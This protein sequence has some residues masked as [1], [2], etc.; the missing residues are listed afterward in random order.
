LNE[1]KRMT[2]AVE[3]YDLLIVGS[4]QAGNPL[5]GAF[6][7]AGRRVALVERA[8][9][10]GTCINYGCTP[11]KTM[12]ASAQRAHLART[13]PPL[14]VDVSS[15]RVNMERVRQRKRE[16]VAQFREGNEKRFAKGNPELVR[17]V[18]SFR[19][20]DF[21]RSRQV[22][23]R[24]NE[25]GERVLAAD[26]IVIDTGTSPRA[27]Q[28]EG[29][30]GVPFLDNVSVM[31]LGEVPRHLLVL[32]GG[33]IGVEFGQMFRRFGSEV[34]LLQAG[35]QILEREDEDI[36][37]EAEKILREDGVAIRTQVRVRAVSGT[38]G[39][40]QV[41]LEGGE[42]VEG[43]HLLVATGRAPNTADLNLRA[44][45][46]DCD[47][48]GY[49]RVNERLETTAAGVYAVGD[50]KG[51]P[52]FTHIAYDDFR[53][54]RENLLRGGSRTTKDRPVP[55]VVYM[56]PQLGRVGMTEREA[57]AAGRAIR[58]AKMPYS[59]VARAVETGETRGVM[60]VLV[61]SENGQIL[62]AAMLGAEGGEMM[63]M[64]E[65]AMMGRLPYTALADAVLAHPALAEAL[66]NVFL[67]WMDQS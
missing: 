38:E 5:A 55:Y 56:D 60:K 43:S 37:A 42:T 17:G 41:G 13:A 59:S 49:I 15:V 62:G 23:V 47:E 36:A 16:I 6:A 12:A 30:G 63:S 65:I 27:P 32:G 4:G 11:T 58:V 66:N 22:E 40:I 29:L 34:T 67:H 19:D 26:L 46:V 24:L 14:G 21:G 64:V 51:G 18:A 35:R 3:R 61:D 1:E 10:G 44:A 7:D 52:A 9:V 54:L 20:V 57:R 39:R 25:G 45:G 2:Q 28:I 8:A 50:V 31:E 33:Y 48:H 53:I